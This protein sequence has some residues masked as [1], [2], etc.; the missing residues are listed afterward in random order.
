M[1]A[2]VALNRKLFY[3]LIVIVLVV[4]LSLSIFFSLQFSTNA[5]VQE[6]KPEPT[7]EATA[8]P[9]PTPTPT[10][11]SMDSPTSTLTSSPQPTPYLMTKNEAVI[12]ATPLIEQYASENNRTIT[13]IKATFYPGLKD[14][15]NTRGGVTLINGEIT[16]NSYF[17]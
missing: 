15:G 17:P 4:C 14:L 6:Q 2:K 5:A 1:G 9:N 12:A 13:S 7:L 11:Q 3:V 8:T 10:N 16:P